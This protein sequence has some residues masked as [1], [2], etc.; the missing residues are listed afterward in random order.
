[1]TGIIV[2]V[3]T[4]P[5]R[6]WP[7]AVR[8]RLQVHHDDTFTGRARRNLPRHASRMSIRIIL[9]HVNERPTKTLVPARRR[10]ADVVGCFP[11]HSAI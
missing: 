4:H 8:D 9:S 5:E 7:F 3:E 1:M 11:H 6:R 10:R 2:R